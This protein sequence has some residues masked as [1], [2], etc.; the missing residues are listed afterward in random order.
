MF[1]KKLQFY[2]FSRLLTKFFQN[3]RKK[4]R[5]WCQVH[6]IRVH[7]NFKKNWWSQ[8]GFLRV[9]RSLTF[10]VKKS[11]SNQNYLTY[12]QWARKRCFVGEMFLAELLTPHSICSAE[13]NFETKGFFCQK[14][15]FD[16][17]FCFWI[18]K[19]RICGTSFQ[20]GCQKQ[21]PRDQRN[22][23]VKLYLEEDTILCLLMVVL[24]KVWF[25]KKTQG[26]SV[27]HSTRPVEHSKGPNS[28]RN[29]TFLF[30]G[31]ERECF[32]FLAQR[33]WQSC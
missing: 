4:I 15:M 26:S 13:K 7:K 1:F 20:Q 2:Y 29:K 8:E 16:N 30:L 28:G 17:F 10:R 21:N 18:K 3:R 5:Q 33:S 14:D 12:G 25:A 22:F 6:N 11:G 9:R 19:F 23:L 27:R 24:R 32:G 31:S